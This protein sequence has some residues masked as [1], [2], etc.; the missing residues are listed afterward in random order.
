[1]FVGIHE[2]GHCMSKKIGHGDE[3]WQNFRFLLDNAVKIGIYQPV[4]YKKDNVIYC[5]MPITDNP[6]YDL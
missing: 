1:M 5:G 3:F 2:I 4:D 6:Y